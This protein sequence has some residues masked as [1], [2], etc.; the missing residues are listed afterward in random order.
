LKGVKDV[1]KRGEGRRRTASTGWNERSSR[2]RVFRLM[3]ESRERD[4]ECRMEVCH[5]HRAVADR[6]PAGE[7]HLSGGDKRL[8]PT[9]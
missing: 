1:L 5:P 3:I 2:N 8:D 9:G 7:I 4:L 6:L